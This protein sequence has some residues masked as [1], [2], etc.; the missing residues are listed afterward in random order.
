MKAKVAGETL[1]PLERVALLK[2]YGIKRPERMGL[3]FAGAGGEFRSINHLQTF[4]KTLEADLEAMPHHSFG[5]SSGKEFVAQFK[6]DLDR[7]TEFALENVVNAENTAVKLDNIDPPITREEDILKDAKTQLGITLGQIQ[8][9]IIDIVGSFNEAFA[10]DAE[11]RQAQIDM[12]IALSR[13]GLAPVLAGGL[14]DVLGQAYL[15][16]EPRDIEELTGHVHA[17]SSIAVSGAISRELGVMAADRSAETAIERVAEK[18]QKERERISSGMHHQLTQ[19]LTNTSVY[20]ASLVDEAAQRVSAAKL[21]DAELAKRTK[22]YNREILL[23]SDP[24]QSTAIANAVKSRLEDDTS[25][26]RKQLAKE[27]HAAFPPVIHS[28][29]DLTKFDEKKHKTTQY[30]EKIEPIKHFIQIYFATTVLSRDYHHAK[31]K[32]HGY[33]PATQVATFADYKPMA[34][35]KQVKHFPKTMAEHPMLL[36]LS[37]PVVKTGKGRRDRNMHKGGKKVRELYTSAIPAIMNN[38]KEYG[39][40]TTGRTG[41]IDQDCLL[42]DALRSYAMVSAIMDIETQHGPHASAMTSS[43]IIP[44]YKRDKHK[45]EAIKTLMETNL[46]FEPHPDNNEFPLNTPLRIF[47]N[48]PDYVGLIADNPNVQTMLASLMTED[49]FVL[50]CLTDPNIVDPEKGRNKL[51]SHANELFR[52]LSLAKVPNEQ[53]ATL[54]SEAMA[55][56]DAQCAKASMV[57]TVPTLKDEATQLLALLRR[58]FTELQQLGKV[59]AN[60]KALLEK[61]SKM[62]GA[63][64]ISGE[65]LSQIRERL[66]NIQSV[67]ISMG[68]SKD[69]WHKFG[70]AADL[71][72]KLKNEKILVEA[73]DY[74]QKEV[75]NM[76]T[77]PASSSPS[78]HSKQ[79]SPSDSSHSVRS[80][81]G[82]FSSNSESSKGSTSPTP[83]PPD[84][85]SSTSPSLGSGSESESP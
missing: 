78:A 84:S 79:S 69:D 52:V 32:K 42:E 76:T 25:A 57:K 13:L 80:R 77:A 39:L 3:L 37:E 63:Q 1:P 17:I 8:H 24:T 36:M 58:D 75:L 68:M 45:L 73:L 54:K 66:L 6:K 10:D 2:E 67:C 64:A 21:S 4:L 46:F 15:M 18:T 12:V 55:Y 27:E 22:A 47:L 59:D 50:R 82:L 81:L 71:C 53:I 30:L 26:M 33:Q 35:G 7:Y 43:G 70:Q 29:L 11:A 51:N 74:T 48:D 56:I 19:S 85:P 61:L 83:T 65:E 28:I 23:A 38:R 40:K 5:L 34:R 31:N 41:G 44:L 60:F 62:D 49:N 72:L 9:N 14:G 16:Y 20:C